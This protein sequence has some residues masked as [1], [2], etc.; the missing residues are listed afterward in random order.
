MKTLF[1]A[2]SKWNATSLTFDH[3]TSQRSGDW[4]VGDKRPFASHSMSKPLSASTEFGQMTV[5][6]KR[7]TQIG[8][9]FFLRTSTL[10][11]LRESQLQ[12]NRESKEG[13]TKTESST[14]AYLCVG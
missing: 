9:V 2:S 7:K 5:I 14:L 13:N 3:G 8:G 10:H 1:S 12:D 11:E 4:K 6:D